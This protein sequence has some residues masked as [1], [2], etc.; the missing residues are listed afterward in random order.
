M[1][2]H[3]ETGVRQCAQQKK[4][5]HDGR[6]PNAAGEIDAGRGIRLEQV[7]L[8]CGCHQG[9]AARRYTLR[10]VARARSCAQTPLRPGDAWAVVAEAVHA[11]GG[12]G[13]Q[14]LSSC[15][16]LIDRLCARS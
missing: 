15:A 16:H 2:A 7:P 3:L 8:R 13:V 4:P 6:S 14:E 9:Q 10:K 1:D 12:N 5:Q 11:K